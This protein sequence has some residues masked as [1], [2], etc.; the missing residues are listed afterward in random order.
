[1]AVLK[2]VCEQTPTPIRETNP[3]VPDWLAALVEKLHAK[4]PAARFQSAAEVAELLGR[5]LAHV[6]HPSVVPPPAVVKPADGPP[7]PVRPPRGGRRCAAAAAVLVVTLAVLS[8]S[9]AT[10][11]T[12]VRAT[13]FRVFEPDGVL[14][15]ETDDPNVKVTV[16]GDGRL[17]VTGTGQQEIR[18]K[19][20]SYRVLADRDG[21]RVPLDRELVTVSRHGRETV[22]GK[23]ES[24]P[25]QAAKADKGAFVLMGAGTER[26]FDTLAEAVVGSTD[27]D[28]IEV[29]GNGLFMTDPIRLDMH[30]LTIRAGPGFRPV[31]R[32][33]SNSA[34]RNDPL[35]STVAT[36]VLEGLELQRF[37]PKE[38][39]TWPPASLVSTVAPLR[40]ANCRFVVA[41]SPWQTCIYSLSR[42]V[43]FTNCE[44]ISPGSQFVVSFTPPERLLSLDNCIHLGICLDAL[45]YDG[46][47]PEESRVLIKR[48]TLVPTHGYALFVVVFRPERD[49]IASAVQ[50]VRV[51]AT[52]T[53][54]AT[55]FPLHFIQTGQ[56]MTPLG[57]GEVEELLPR[58][59]SWRDRGNVYATGGASIEWSASG[60]ANRTTLGNPADW[61]KY[62]G[63]TDGDL[64]GG[65]IR[66]EGGNPGA[67][68]LDDITKITPQDFRLRHDSAGSRAGKDG[69]DLGADVDLVGPG[70]AYERWNKTPAYQQWLKETAVLKK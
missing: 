25:P 59:F 35:L 70:A 6:Q 31:L 2:R 45:H 21:K 66:F 36:L 22:R 17:V 69:K 16:E 52:G 3:E 43:A 5:H 24:P 50:K 11:V 13:V 7:A 29:R 44:F 12:N 40:A 49:G 55:P 15:V 10:G 37:G 39:L 23:L 53:I 63:D 41:A 68:Q 8:V 33:T 18:L 64:R 26:K 28:T 62:W 14:V 1:M 30:A 34:E 48:S 56:K 51:E 9:E 27:G 42:H 46:P 54:F 32:L 57:Q 60:A 47:P 61:K 58:L 4:D 20:G 19:P 38:G 67:R 65:T